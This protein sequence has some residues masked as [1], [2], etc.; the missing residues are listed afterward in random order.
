MVTSLQQPQSPSPACESGCMC[1][2]RSMCHVQSCPHL[3]GQRC[4][5]FPFRCCTSCS[6]FD[7][8]DFHFLGER[9]SDF[10]EWGRISV[11]KAL[12]KMGILEFFVASVT[13]E[14]G[15]ETLSQ[16][17]LCSAI[18]LA[19]PPNQCVVFTSSLAGL[20]AA[21]NCTSKVRPHHK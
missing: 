2:Q 7:S 8:C 14:D 6:R 16:R 4:W 10:Y 19:R 15:M 12:E 9:C 17:F 1:C 3:T 11:R 18:K 5:K 20:T 13:S 21:H